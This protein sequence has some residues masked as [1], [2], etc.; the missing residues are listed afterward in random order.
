[1]QKGLFSSLPSISHW[2]ARADLALACHWAARAAMDGPGAF[3]PLFRSEPG[4]VLVPPPGL[5]LAEVTPEAMEERAEEAESLAALS[6]ARCLIFARPPA[7]MALAALAESELPPICPDSAL[8][9][10]RHVVMDAPGPLAAPGAIA[11]VIGN[12][13]LLTLGDSPAEALLRLV[14]FE[15]AAGTYLAALASTRALRIMPPEAA[16]TFAMPCAR[17]FLERLRRADG[18]P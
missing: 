17:A 3:S 8:F 18:A 15:R 16:A 10:R 2:P 9:H 5:P 12:H 6:P 14:L 11:A 1:M 13:G 4:R 7:A